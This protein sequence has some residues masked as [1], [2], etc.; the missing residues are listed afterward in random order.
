MATGNLNTMSAADFIQGF[1]RVGSSRLGIRMVTLAMAAATAGCAGFKPEPSAQ[2]DF[3]QRAVHRE[4]PQYR[5]SVAVPSIEE[6]T[7]YFD[8]KLDGIGVQP[9]WVQVENR[10]D[11]MAHFLPHSMDGDFFAALEV[12]YPY[13]SGWR[14]KRNAAIDV[15][16]LTNAMPGRIPAHS[17]R[18]GFVFTHLD[19][20][21]KHVCVA[22]SSN[23]HKWQE[24]RFTFLVAVPGLKTDWQEASWRNLTNGVQEI[25]CDDG[26]LRAALEK[27]PRATTDKKGRKEGDPMNLAVIG[28][29]EDLAATAGCDWDVTERVTSGTAWRTM[30]SF[31]FGSQYRYSPVSPLYYEG[32]HQDVAL[33]K[34]RD[35]VKQRNHLRLWLT[36]LR[37]NGKPVW[38]GQVSRDIGVR[39]TLKTINLTTHKINPNVDEARSYL[40]GDLIH[41][42]TVK[43]WGYVKGAEAAPYW[44]P[45]HNLTGDPYFTDG[46][47]AVIELSADAIQPAGV[48]LMEWETPPTKNIVRDGS[49]GDGK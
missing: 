35:S 32:R 38:V 4:D 3:L 34:A 45:R 18:S 39:W 15:F 7:K 31:I 6:T 21:E 9:V 2:A 10:S 16:F 40:V 33:Q 47:R 46:L 41:G 48:R 12:A 19:L 23:P 20:G 37:Y 24:S 44:Q 49:S 26:R 1:D 27:L 8:R 17:E 13:H 36:P 28:S 25:E 11:S 30:M 29:L 14:P 22:V 43:W 42:Q 5:V